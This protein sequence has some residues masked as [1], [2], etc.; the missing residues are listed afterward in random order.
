MNHHKEITEQNTKIQKE[1]E[2]NVTYWIQWNNI[3]IVQEW[4]T[5]ITNEISRLSET[6]WTDIKIGQENTMITNR[7]VNIPFIQ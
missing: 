2:T 1:K 3:I 7:Q 6:K 5:M 4:N